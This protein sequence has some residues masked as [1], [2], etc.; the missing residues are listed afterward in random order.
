VTVGWGASEIELITSNG[1]SPEKIPDLAMIFPNFIAA[2]NSTDTTLNMVSKF[3]PS[4]PIAGEKLA[5]CWYSS[6]FNCKE[7]IMSTLILR[8]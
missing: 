1:E 6:R 4:N 3:C 8:T 2:G 7:S 5:L